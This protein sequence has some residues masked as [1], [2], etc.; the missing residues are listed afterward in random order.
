MG[1]H[2]YPP[3]LHNFKEL[4]KFCEAHSLDCALHRTRYDVQLVPN[5]IRPYCALFEAGSAVQV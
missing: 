2:L 5:I 3:N 1:K 4:V